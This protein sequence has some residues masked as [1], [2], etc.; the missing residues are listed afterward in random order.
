MAAASGLGGQG[1]WRQPPAVTLPAHVCPIPVEKTLSQKS[2]GGGIQLKIVQKTYV[3]IPFRWMWDG[4][5][6][7]FLANELNPEI[8]IDAAALDR[9]PISDFQH[10]ADQIHSKGLST[11]LHAPFFDLSAGSLDPEIRGVT[12]RRFNE[13]LRLVP[14]FKPKSVVCHAGYDRRRY[15]YFRDSRVE[16]S[17]KL[18]SWLGKSIQE[19]GSLLMLENV[20]VDGP[21][22][23]RVFFENLEDYGVG[24]CF[25]IGHQTVFGIASLEEKS[26][27]KSRASHANP[28]FAML[29]TVR[30]YAVERLTESP[31]ADEAR[32][33]HAEFFFELASEADP[34]LFDVEHAVWR[35]KLDSE[36]S[37]IRA[38]LDWCLE[39]GQRDLG[40]KIIVALDNFWQVGHVAEP[41]PHPAVGAQACNIGF[42]QID[43]SRVKVG[44]AHDGLEQ[45]GL[46]DAVAADDADGLALCNLQADV[47]Q[48]H[49]VAVTR[50]H[51]PEPHLAAGSVH[52]VN[53]SPR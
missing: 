44:V 50:A 16:E 20:Y 34:K 43:L 28:S 36:Y 31:E 27:L 53:A 52:A 19:A 2:G 25:D 15:G 47:L 23:I 13:L 48:H 42:G 46:A 35:N 29:E 21:E 9:Y 6:E 39:G 8:G 26:L 30:E 49:G 24:F 38:A 12:R 22:D 10:I 45:R 41:G 17:L 11:T 37:N 3:N 18:W 5:L 51:T 32:K 40:L 33:K 7:R 1:Y 4:Y 14:I